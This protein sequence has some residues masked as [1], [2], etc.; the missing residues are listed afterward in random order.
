MS[1]KKFANMQIGSDV[2]PYE[3]VR[4]VSDKTLE[5]R[6]MSAT[7]DPGWRPKFVQG[8]FTAHCTNQGE[9]RWIYK[10]IPE[11]ES[12]RIRKKKSGK[13]WVNKGFIF[14]LSDRPVMFHDY[15]F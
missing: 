14:R 6:R 11:A 9:Q 12:I 15:N 2:F 7:L 10:S 1:E 8:G 4:F 3:V 13:A 5:V